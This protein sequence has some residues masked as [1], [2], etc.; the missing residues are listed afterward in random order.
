ML[1]HVAE[2]MLVLARGGA[3]DAVI[4]AHHRCDARLFDANLERPQ[5][6]LSHCALVDVRALSAPVLLL[7]VL[8]EVLDRRRK[9]L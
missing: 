6:E 2:Q 9:V 1:E 3:V 4:G 8:G 7:V 5:L